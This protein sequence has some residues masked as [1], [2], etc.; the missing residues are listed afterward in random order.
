VQ[1]SHVLLHPGRRDRGRTMTSAAVP[2]QINT[3]KLMA[4]VPATGGARRQIPGR[5]S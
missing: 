1:D 4:F 2:I 3:G 5:Q